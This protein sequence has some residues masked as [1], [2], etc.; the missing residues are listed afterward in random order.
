MPMMTIYTGGIYAPASKIT[1]KNRSG[2]RTGSPS[3][4]L[5]ACYVVASRQ[6][7]IL[8]F[9]QGLTLIHSCLPA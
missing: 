3:F 6:T 7:L 2:F 8:F 4:P 1:T 5:S 9:T